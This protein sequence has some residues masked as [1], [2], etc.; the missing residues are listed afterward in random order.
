MFVKIK[1]Q[2]AIIV[3][4]LL[5]LLLVVGTA[6]PAFAAETDI[7]VTYFKHWNSPFHVRSGGSG[8]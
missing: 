7:D 8:A 6:V 3:A 5:T 1:K 4:M 2:L